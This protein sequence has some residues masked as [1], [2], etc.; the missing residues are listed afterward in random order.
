MATKKNKEEFMRKTIEKVEAKIINMYAIWSAK[1]C[2]INDKQ[3][4]S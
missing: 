3:G 2:V 1:L 4:F